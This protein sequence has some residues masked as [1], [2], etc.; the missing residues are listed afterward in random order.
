[1]NVIGFVVVNVI[2]FDSLKVITLSEEGY[3]ELNLQ[4]K[5]FGTERK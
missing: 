4:W 2:N 3:K 1:M 5:H